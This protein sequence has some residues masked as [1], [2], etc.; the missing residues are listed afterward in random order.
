MK[1]RLLEKRLPRH[2]D[3]PFTPL[4]ANLDPGYPAV[5]SPVSQNIANR[6]EAVSGGASGAEHHFLGR[7]LRRC[8]SVSGDAHHV[9]QNKC[10]PA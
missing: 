4:Q 8:L 6:A 5:P 1:Y 3:A 10:I 2:P 9:F 7:R